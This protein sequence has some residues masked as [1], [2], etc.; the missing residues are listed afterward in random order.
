MI[1][2]GNNFIYTSAAIAYLVVLQC[3]LMISLNRAVSSGMVEEYAN[4]V[5]P[6]L[7][8]I[9]SLLSPTKA[10]NWLGDID[11]PNDLFTWLEKILGFPFQPASIG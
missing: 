9:S 10:E 1:H 11:F 3:Y 2:L 4:Q 7:C 5:Y 6:S 8:L